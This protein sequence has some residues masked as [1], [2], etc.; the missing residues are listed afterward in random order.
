MIKVQLQCRAFGADFG[1]IIEVGHKYGNKGEVSKK[2]LEAL[3]D[4]GNAI[5]VNEKVVASAKGIEKELKDANGKVISLEKEIEKAN[6][7]IEK[8][9]SGIA[10]LDTETNAS[11]L[12]KAVKTL[13]ESVNNG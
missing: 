10:G 6:A 12:K 5:I 9:S 1:D 3:I 11:D 13:Q 2:D 4:E 8:L 7:E